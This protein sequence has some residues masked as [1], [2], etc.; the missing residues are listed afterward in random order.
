MK[1]PTPCDD[2]CEATCHEWHRVAFKRTHSAGSCQVERHGGV[3]WNEIRCTMLSAMPAHEHSFT[4]CV[5]DEITD[6]IWVLLGG[7]A[8]K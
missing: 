5:E 1:C 4:W 2:D 6:E 8:T 7:K 3:S